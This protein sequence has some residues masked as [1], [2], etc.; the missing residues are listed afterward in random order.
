MANYQEDYPR[1]PLWRK[2]GAT[3][4]TPVVVALP[5]NVAVFKVFVDTL[6]LLAMGTSPTAIA[7]G[8]V[9]AV[10]T[11]SML[12]TAAGGDFTLFALGIET[13]A[14]AYNA[15]AATVDAALETILGAGSITTTGGALPTDVVLTFD[16]A[17]Y[18]ATSPPDISVKRNSVTGTGNP[19]P[20]IVKTTLAVNP[21]E[22]LEASTQEVFTIDPSKT[23][24]LYIATVASTGNYRV[25][26]LA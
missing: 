6:S 16:Q 25:S 7:V 23:A 9:N 22:Y 24:F 20:N 10:R 15:A 14:I 3:S 17:P 8:A 4:T 11:L 13:V 26:A 1:A 5:P 2:T 18:V 12:G 21:Y 19:R